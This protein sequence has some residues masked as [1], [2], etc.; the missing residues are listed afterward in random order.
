MSYLL[1]T[2]TCSAFLKGD[3]RVFNRFIQ[4]S[5]G[6]HI[7]ILTLAELYSWIYVADDP[8]RSRRE[9]GLQTM[10]SDVLVIP[11]DH[12]V[13]RTF[14]ETRAVLQRRGT[15]VATVDLL[16][17]STAL[18]HDFTVATHNVRHFQLV[19]DLRMEDWIA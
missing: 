17:A 4:H 10:L 16:I 2:D 14:G 7:S 13:A 5:G 8:T 1:D 9:E 3:R 18:V 6:L 12:D 15:T 19:P 11:V